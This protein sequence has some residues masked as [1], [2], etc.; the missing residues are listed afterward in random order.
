MNCQLQSI[1]KDYMENRDI[2]KKVF[3]MENTEMYAVCGAQI[4]GHHRLIR[5]EEL[6][7]AKQLLKR[8]TGIFSSFRGNGEMSVITALALSENPEEKWRQIQMMYQALKEEFSGSTYLAM[9]AVILSEII[10]ERDA[11]S[12]IER[13]KRLYR[14]MKQE[15][16]LLTSSEDSVLAILLTFSEKNNDALIQEMEEAYRTLKEC[17]CWASSQSIQTVSHILCLG[18]GQIDHETRRLLQLYQSLESVG[19]KYGKDY[20]LSALAVLAISEMKIEDAVKD[21]LDVDEFLSEQKGYHGI[22]GISKKDRLMHAAMLVSLSDEDN[23]ISDSGILTSTLAMI[24]ARQAMLCTIAASS[25]AM[26]LAAS[27]SN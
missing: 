4:C 14:Q 3:R 12:Y 17:L 24:A 6:A 13:G 1:C 18:S 15:H 10:G 9:A 8:D 23:A 27:S 21:I 16:P 26:S 19:I 7:S 5:E 22:L 25:A 2:L 11:G 20:Q